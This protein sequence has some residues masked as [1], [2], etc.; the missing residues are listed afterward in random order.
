MVVPIFNNP[1]PDDCI[2]GLP[3]D[4]SPETRWLRA[5]HNTHQNQTLIRLHEEIPCFQQEIGAAAVQTKQDTVAVAGDTNTSGVPPYLKRK[6]LL[7]RHDESD[8]TSRTGTNSCNCKASGGKMA[9]LGDTSMVSDG[10]DDGDRIHSEYSDED[11]DDHEARWQ[12]ELGAPRDGEF[13]AR[14]RWLRRKR[15]LHLLMTRGV[16]TMKRAHWR[17][18]DD[19]G[20]D[21]DNAGKVTA[22][23]AMQL[24]RPQ[25]QDS[26]PRRSGK[27]KRNDTDTDT[28]TDTETTIVWSES[29][30]RYSD[31]NDDLEDESTTSGK[32]QRVEEGLRASADT[33]GACEVAEPP[34]TIT[35][36][37]SEASALS[38]GPRRSQRIREKL[39]SACATA[40]IS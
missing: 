2:T 22:V 39:G 28:D 12:L 11:E 32:R 5:P 30:N 19:D 37:L 1:L 9:I 36:H 13:P 29:Y 27:R 17:H 8:E 34:I 35:G 33:D 23:P 20:D 7:L 18:N 40:P 21:L 24:A 10:D 38:V 14:V 15:L 26:P 6:Q 25:I 16:T 4:D 3:I 31:D